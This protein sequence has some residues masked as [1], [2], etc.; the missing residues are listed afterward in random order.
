MSQ[1]EIEYNLSTIKNTYFIKIFIGIIIV[2][3]LSFLLMLSLSAVKWKLS[4][5]LVAY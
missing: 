2:I 1:E 4:Q 3:V 5:R